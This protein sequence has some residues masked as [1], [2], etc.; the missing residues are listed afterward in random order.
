[1]TF[2]PDGMALALTFWKDPYEIG[3]WN[4]KAGD[5]IGSPLEG[6]SDYTT[7]AAFSPDGTKLASASNDT[8]LRLWNTELGRLLE[9]PLKGTTVWSTQ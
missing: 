8:T 4:I 2:S 7:S 9:L 3:F 5:P 1:M 6:C